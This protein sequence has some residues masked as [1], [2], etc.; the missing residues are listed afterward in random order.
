M[1]LKK[2]ASQISIIILIVT[3]L[4][5]TLLPL[6][7]LIISSL[8][9]T[10]NSI[11]NSYL[12]DLQIEWSNYTFAW[13]YVRNYVFNSVFLTVTIVIS[14]LI[15]SLMAAF[16][17]A[18]YKFPF[19]NTLYIFIISLM[20]VP[21]VLSLI[22]AYILASKFNLIDT[23]LG[24]ILPSI[25]AGLPF[26]IILMRSFFETLPEELFEAAR[27][28]GSKLKDE[29][30][31]IIIPLSKPIITTVAI[32]NGVN[33]WND[34]IWP[35]L[36]LITESKLTIAVGIQAFSAEMLKPNGIR[37]YAP[38]FAGYVIVSIPLAILFLFVSKQFIE[39]ITNG[40]LKA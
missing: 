10:E 15:I 26:A 7:E 38:A 23:Y 30:L 4:S 25:S 22:P 16:V 28:D 33:Y 14:I 21:F 17:F 18:R 36:I 2:N 35:R 20:M 32:V 40:A 39:G 19:K 3:L 5:M 9:T 24:V 1:K 12:P 37:V 8:K 27:I 29:L 34:Y 11:H 13:E 31:N 6:V